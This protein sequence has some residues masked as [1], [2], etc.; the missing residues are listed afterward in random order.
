M[1]DGSWFPAFVAATVAALIATPLLARWSRRRTRRRTPLATAA[2]PVVGVAAALPFVI[3]DLDSTLAIGLIAAAW[4]WAAGQ[5]M[6]RGLLPTPL[7]RLMIVAAA[8]MVVAADLR[9]RVTGVAVSYTHLTLPTILL[10]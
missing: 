10:V 4:L 8:G 5:L 3:P 9:L 2:G 6:E 7:R 1:I